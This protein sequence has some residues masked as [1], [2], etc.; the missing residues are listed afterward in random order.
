MHTAFLVRKSQKKRS[1]G[2]HRHRR[3]DN[4]NVDRSEIELEAVGSISLGQDRVQWPVGVNA[5][6]K[7]RVS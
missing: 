4:I 5:A 7:R 6:V 2:R 1:F 3:E